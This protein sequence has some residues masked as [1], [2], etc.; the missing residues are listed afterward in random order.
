MSVERW[1]I[2]VMGGKISKEGGGVMERLVI[3][4]RRRKLVEVLPLPSL[5]PQLPL[6]FPYKG[7][8]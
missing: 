5:L 1:E 6:L 8:R 2:F 7:S 3:D 4:I